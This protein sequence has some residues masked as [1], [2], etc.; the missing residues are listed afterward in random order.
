MIDKVAKKE[1]KEEIKNKQTNK[2]TKK[3]TITKPI[4]PTVLLET[5]CDNR[6]MNMISSQRQELWRFPAD[7]INYKQ[8]SWNQ[9]Q[10]RIN[11]FSHQR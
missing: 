11:E 1:T 9:Y 8:P 3:Q 10:P 2:Q 4:T 5:G 6:S 7:P